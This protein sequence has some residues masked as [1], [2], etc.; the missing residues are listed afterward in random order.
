MYN[1]QLSLFL[2][3]IMLSAGLIPF[4]IPHVALP[5]VWFGVVDKEYK[6]GT[7]LF[8]GDILLGRH[9]EGLMEKHGREY[10]FMNVRQFVEHAD[11]AVAN[12]EGAVPQKHKRAEDFTFQFSV[13]EEYLDQIK[14]SGFDIISLANNHA[15]DFGKAGYDNTLLRCHESGLHCHGHPYEL[16]DTSIRTIEVGDAS[17]GLLFLHGIAVDSTDVLLQGLLDRLFATTDLQLVYI[18][19]GIEYELTHSDSQE[20][21]A[22]LLIDRGIDGV[23]GHHPHVVQD[24]GLYKGKPIFYSLGNFVFDQYFSDMVQE[25]LALQLDISKD[26]VE[27]TLV[28][29][30]SAGAKSQPRLMNHTE[31]ERFLSTLAIEEEFDLLT[32]DAPKISV[33]RGE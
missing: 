27:Y 20:E 3:L 7:L 31:K 22:H 9:V 25:G 8:V 4:F 13:K 21:L 26:R 1:L 16:Q 11:V 18:H 2:V 30:T 17:V 14:E 29:I 23:V 32:A 24:I 33:A 6:N 19:W 28:P 15:Y 5:S 10:P 12:F